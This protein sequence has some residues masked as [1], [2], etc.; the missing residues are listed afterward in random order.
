[1]SSTPATTGE[2]TRRFG[3]IRIEAA[4]KIYC[5]LKSGFMAVDV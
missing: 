5:D 2:T 1:M 4:T 3:A